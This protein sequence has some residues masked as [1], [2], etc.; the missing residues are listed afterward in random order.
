MPKPRS[1]LVRPNANQVRWMLENSAP[2]RDLLQANNLSLTPSGCI[3]K[4]WVVA[5]AR[6]P[7]APPAP[8]PFGPLCEPA[9]ATIG[10]IPRDFGLMAPEPRRSAPAARRRAG[11]S[12]RPKTRRSGPKGG[13]RRTKRPK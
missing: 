9:L 12:S 8:S 13:A 5:A 4:V 3:V 1:R 6:G 10:T 11:G 2:L 7:K